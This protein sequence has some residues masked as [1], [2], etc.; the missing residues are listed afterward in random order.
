MFDKMQKKENFSE[1]KQ[2]VYLLA[3]L[4]SGMTL[5]DFQKM[6]NAEIYFDNFDFQLVLDFF[7]EFGIVDKE[8]KQMKILKV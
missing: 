1:I 3:F 4:P 5:Y 7:D 6:N 8:K 2:L